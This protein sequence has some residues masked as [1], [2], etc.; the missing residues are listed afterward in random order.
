MAAVALAACTGGVVARRG[1]SDAVVCLNA[2]RG[3]RCA[4]QRKSQVA[5]PEVKYV[6]TLAPQDKSTE[7]R[8]GAQR[9]TGACEKQAGRTG[10]FLDILRR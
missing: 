5:R 1:H 6:K 3:D 7:R 10:V 9:S 8:S 2:M 4:Q